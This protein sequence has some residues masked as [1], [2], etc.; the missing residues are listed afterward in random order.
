MSRKGSRT[1]RSSTKRKDAGGGSAS[2]SNSSGESSDEGL[3]GALLSEDVMLIDKIYAKL[4]L[5]SLDDPDVLDF[6]AK[7]ADC[8][9][10]I[11]QLNHI[12]II[13]MK[14]RDTRFV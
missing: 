11:R 2:N 4:T 12:T 6:Q 9:E 1:A 5:R 13:V 7:W 14:T 10:A 8:E 3:S